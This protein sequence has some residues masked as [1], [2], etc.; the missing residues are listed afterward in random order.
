MIAWYELYNCPDTWDIDVLLSFLNKEIYL[1]PGAPV[2]SY[3]IMAFQTTYLLG[4]VY[5]EVEDPV[6][7]VARLGGVTCLSI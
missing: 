6:D 4:P 5:R 7:E 1:I 3:K 2:D